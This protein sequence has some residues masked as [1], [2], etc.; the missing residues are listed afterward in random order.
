MLFS[1]SLFMAG[2]EY[3]IGGINIDPGDM[4][5][6]NKLHKIIVEST[7]NVISIYVCVSGGH[8]WVATAFRVPEE[9]IVGGG[10]VEISFGDELFVGDYS[11]EF[12][13][14]PEL[15]AKKFARLLR[16]KLEEEL[17]V[18]FKGIITDTRI[19]KMNEYWADKE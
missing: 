17:E 1:W 19:Y 12:L 3:R 16:P 13:A 6:K 14:I 5:P 2:L 15:V 9:R 11:G 10:S 4:T 7:G 8:K 18:K